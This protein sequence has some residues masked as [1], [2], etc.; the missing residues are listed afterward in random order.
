MRVEML[1][2]LQRKI[3]P[4]A[5]EMAAGARCA[6]EVI[7]GV[8]LGL[9]TCRDLGRVWNVDDLRGNRAAAHVRGILGAGAVD[10]GDLH[11]TG[12]FL[13]LHRPCHAQ[14]RLQ[15]RNSVTG[16]VAGYI[17]AHPYAAVAA[18][19]LRLQRRTGQAVYIFIGWAKDL[20]GS[21][22]HRCRAARATKNQRTAEKEDE[23]LRQPDL[24]SPTPGIVNSSYAIQV[25]EQ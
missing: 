17:F 4:H 6:I 3:D 11:E 20:V 9:P 16:L 24:H 25:M 22:Q 2:I 8:I 10:H 7:G 21:D 18:H 23:F 19:L 5:V 12:L 13:F 1:D 14:G 15:P